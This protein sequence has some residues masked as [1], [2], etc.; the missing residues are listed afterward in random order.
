MNLIIVSSLID[1]PHSNGLAVRYITMKSKLT[2]ELPVLIEVT[3]EEKDFYYKY[4]K[5]RGMMD[6]VDQYITPCENELG[7]RID[8]EYAFPLTI[9][10]NGISFD[11][12][13]SILTQL[14]GLKKI[15]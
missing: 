2:L 1:T 15:D 14:D 6:Y 13:W 11:N 9:R 10:T 8:T 4:M 7:I 12:T 3:Q 5:K